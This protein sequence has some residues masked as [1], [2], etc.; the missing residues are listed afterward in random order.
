M[1]LPF[2]PADFGFASL[3]TVQP[4][5]IIDRFGRAAGIKIQNIRQTE[6]DG[7]KTEVCRRRAF[8]TVQ[9]KNRLAVTPAHPEQIIHIHLAHQYL[10]PFYAFKQ[11]LRPLVVDA[12]QISLQHPVCKLRFIRVFRVGFD[13]FAV[14][15][16]QVPGEAVRVVK[17]LRFFLFAAA[18]PHIMTAG[19]QDQHGGLVTGKAAGLI[20][21]KIGHDA[22]NIADMNLIMER[23]HRKL[24][25]DHLG[26]VN[27]ECTDS[28]DTSQIF[29][30]DLLAG[31]RVFVLLFRFLL[32][33]FPQCF[34]RNAHAAFPSSLIRMEGSFRTFSM[35]PAVLRPCRRA[36]YFPHDTIDAVCRQEKGRKMGEF[37]QY[38]PLPCLRPRHFS[39]RAAI[40]PSFPPF[41][42]CLF[43]PAP[44][45]CL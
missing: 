11:L 36:G 18:H 3:R 41:F 23:I 31:R 15:S 33:D 42:P 10:R 44:L 20:A 30:R 22:E 9:I 14:I 12:A 40:I 13:V 16:L 29:V 37:F 17:Q 26:P 45:Y 43:P 5:V 1:L 38:I 25:T 32:Q 24:V 6:Q 19:G 7:A 35:K 2:L 28:L 8:Q 27:A 21:Q 4:A 39:P 34:F